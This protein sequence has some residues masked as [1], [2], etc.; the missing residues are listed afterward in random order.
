MLRTT[1]YTAT[2]E[3]ATK[4][5][6][7]AE[8]LSSALSQYEPVVGTSKRGWVELRMRL[9]A[10]SLLQ[11]FATALSVAA[12]ATGAEA[13]A[14]GVMS[15]NESDQREASCPSRELIGPGSRSA[16]EAA[17]VDSMTTPEHFSECP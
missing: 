7:G 3:V 6:L 12:A 13:I 9:R 4:Q 11:A 14:C 15:E 10:D 1:T 5:A 16:D 2:V 8:P 17:H